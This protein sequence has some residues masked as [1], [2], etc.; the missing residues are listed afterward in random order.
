MARWLFLL[1]AFFTSTALAREDRC[2]RIPFTAGPFGDVTFGRTERWCY[3]EHWAPVGSYFVYNADSEEAK[4]ELAFI[5]E[6]DDTLTHGSISGGKFT[7]HKLKAQGFSPFSVPLRVPSGLKEEPN[8]RA[9]DPRFLASVEGTERL[10]TEAEA[11]VAS[12]VITPGTFEGRVP[13]EALP[14]RGYLWS[15]KGFPLGPAMKKLDTF[16]KARGLRSRAYEWERDNHEYHG[17][18][19]SGHC[20]GWAASSVLREEPTKI[21]HDPRSG[22]TFTISDQKGLMAE[23]D[24]CVSYSFYGRRFPRGVLED[25]T[26]GDFHNVVVYNL[27]ALGRPVAV[28]LTRTRP[29]LNNVFSA[30]KTTIVRTAPTTYE[31]TTVVR[32]HYYD[33]SINELVG[34]APSK[35]LTYRY[36]LETDARGNV[37]SG[38]WISTNPDFL[39]VP[40]SGAR[41]G[42]ENPYVTNALVEAIQDLPAP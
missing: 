21:R 35:T 23:R 38:K 25:I 20:N 27:G 19:W 3:K 13:T 10:L 6:P 24:Y 29:V 37:K 14:F 34:R 17:L 22:V 12:L 41:C 28:D 39:W 31:V 26:P 7:V 15:M 42:D 30:Y 8:P 18:S 36:T 5:I 16:A 1:V 2:Y 4:P 33:Q 11:P 40:L 32:D 9:T